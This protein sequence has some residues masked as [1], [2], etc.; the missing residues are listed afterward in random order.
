MLGFVKKRL[1]DAGAV[2]VFS[3]AVQMKKDRPGVTLSAIVPPGNVDAVE[4]VLF[5]QTGTFGVRRHLVERTKRL[6]REETVDTAFGPVRGKVGPRPAG[7]EVFAP[8]FESCAA[9]SD[10][11]GVPLRDVYRA[12]EAAF[13]AGVKPS[14]SAEPVGHTHDHDHSA[15]GHSHDHS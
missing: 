14:R 12:A 11:K 15:P 5:D 3:T 9:V 8:E 1:F 10:A 4:A 13:G 6:R 2:D 7:G